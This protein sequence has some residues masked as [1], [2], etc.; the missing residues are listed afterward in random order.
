[1]LQID[2]FEKLF[3]KYFQKNI[4]LRI[5]DDDIKTGKFLLI[6][7]HI[8]TNNFYFELVIEN[9]KKIVSFKLPYPFAYDEYP[10]EGIL[11]LDYRFKSLH[12]KKEMSMLM[13]QI[14]SRLVPEK[15]SKFVDQILE[16]Q[17][18]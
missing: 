12:N 15:P 18:T 11:Y 17:F 2:S 8:V 13:S 5:G 4:T 9:T 6:Q 16:I 10:D 7:N 14:C 1:M 3:T